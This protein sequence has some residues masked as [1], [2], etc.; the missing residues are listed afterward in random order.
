MSA[1]CADL[2][3]VHSIIQN[4]DTKG[5]S[6][7]VRLKPIYIGLSGCGIQRLRTLLHAV[8]ERR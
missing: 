4:Q 8:G 5:S 3:F 6:E 1:T 2:V 7:R